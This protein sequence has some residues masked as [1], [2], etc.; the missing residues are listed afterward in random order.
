M[1]MNVYYKFNFDN[2]LVGLEETEYEAFTEA[3]SKKKYLNFL[4][5]IFS[6]MRRK[7]R[8]KLIN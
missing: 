6:V 7:L 3:P 4:R 8:R 1:S 5:P 2:P